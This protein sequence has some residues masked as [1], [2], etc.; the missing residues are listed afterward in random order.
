VID[1]P[2][3]RPP[4]QRLADWAFTCE[5]VNDSVHLYKDAKDSL[6]ADIR[7]VLADHARLRAEKSELRNIMIKWR[8]LCEIGLMDA[9]KEWVRPV[10]LELWGE[11]D[12]LVPCEKTQARA[13][14]KEAK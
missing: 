13:A 7:S 4:E 3:T 11:T 5:N 10:I 1:E 9:T 6:A 14:L 8:R 2:D 12:D